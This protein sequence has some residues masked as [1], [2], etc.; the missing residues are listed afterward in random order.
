MKLAIVGNGAIGNLLA[1][2]CHIQ[3]QEF[4]LVTRTQQA[5][6]LVATDILQRAH[7]I[8][9]QPSTFSQLNNADI[10][11]LPVK[12]Y[13]IADTVA[14]LKP[15]LCAEQ[16]LV[17]LHNGMGVI[18]A[19][20]TLLPNNPIIAA[21]TSHA[22]YK[23]STTTMF[24]TG[25]GMC[26]L[27]YIARGQN[28]AAPLISNDTNR[29][30]LLTSLLTPCCWHADIEQALWDKLAI[31]AVINPL[32]ALHQ[33]KNGQLAQSQYNAIIGEICLETAN[34]MTA[35]GFSAEAGILI[36]R[37]KQVIEATSVN[38]SSMY[39]DIAHKRQSEIV[40]INGY[41]CQQAQIHGINV[42]VNQ[43]LLK[44]ITA[45]EAHY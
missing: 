34:V 25:L 27:G 30:A 19:V 42:P 31:N 5:F 28:S 20:K 8:Q 26:H 3:Q 9:I 39:Q 43:N 12:A 40:F 21:T 38:Y 18:E 16:T 15:H 13:Q 45:L 24:E 29:D 2:K 36:D 33:I 23:P 7:N 4:S 44:R 14:E 11:V 35:C 17:L 32:T 37:V 41:I 22:A 6:T 1:L 10:I